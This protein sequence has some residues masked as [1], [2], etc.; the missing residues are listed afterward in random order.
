M[1]MK[2]IYTRTLYDKRWFAL[3]WMVSFFALAAL[4]VAFFPSMKQDGSLD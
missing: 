1:M 3:G 2:S 4:L